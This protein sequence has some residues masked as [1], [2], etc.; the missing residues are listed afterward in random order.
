MKA[1]LNWARRAGLRDCLCLLMFCRH[2]TSVSLLPPV[3]E[4]VAAVIY[5][6]YMTPESGKLKGR[7]FDRQAFNYKEEPVLAALKRIA[8]D[9]LNVCFDNVGGETLEAM[10]DGARPFSPR[11]WSCQHR[12]GNDHL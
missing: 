2:V 5:S 11:F 9:G 8:P 1:C 3:C 6:T 12:S 4:Y 10:L 7:W